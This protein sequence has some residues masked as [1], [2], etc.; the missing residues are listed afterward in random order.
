MQVVAQ[1]ASRGK[2]RWIDTVKDGFKKRLVW[3]PSKQGEWCMIG[4]NGGGL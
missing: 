3:M 2:K 4:M 1:R